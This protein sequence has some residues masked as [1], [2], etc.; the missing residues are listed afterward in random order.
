MKFHNAGKYNGDE[1]S[2]PQREHPEGFVPF[3][4]AQDMKKLSIKQET[5]EVCEHFRLNPYQLTSVGCMLMVTDK[6][7][8]LADALTKEGIKASVIG[9]LTESNDKIISN[10]EEIRYVDRPAPDELKKI[11]L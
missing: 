3:K 5:I 11:F 8:E 2:L 9:R 7:E 4:E 10:G 1:S 6:G